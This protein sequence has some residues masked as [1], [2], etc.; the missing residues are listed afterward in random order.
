MES[1]RFTEHAQSQLGGVKKENP[2]GKGKLGNETYKQGEV[3]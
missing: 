3:K 2:R 1:N